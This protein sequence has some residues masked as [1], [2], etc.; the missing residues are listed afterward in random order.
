M[1][2]R[3]TAME[4]IELPLIF[5]GL[6]KSERLQKAKEALVMV[7]LENRMNHKPTEL[8]GGQQQRVSIT[9][10]I[11]TNP[12]IILA[13][14]PTGNL[15]SRKSSQYDFKILCG[16]VGLNSNEI[17]LGENSYEYFKFSY[18]GDFGEM[19]LPS[20]FDFLNRKISITQTEMSKNNEGY[21]SQRVNIDEFIVVGILAEGNKGLDFGFNTGPTV[22]FTEEKI[23]S[24]NNW[25]S[26]DE[27]R[28]ITKVKKCTQV[29]R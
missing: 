7:G 3:L 10:A 5:A 22:Y 15:D 24:L 16:R 19:K 12:A 26:T 9:R 14:E 13:D 8:S 25:Y 29:Q 28:E 23:N 20:S 21:F 6:G 11:V 18:E 27:G 1:I 2:P 17:M 4:N